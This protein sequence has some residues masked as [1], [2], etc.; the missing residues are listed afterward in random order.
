MN[1]NT[2]ECPVEVKKSHDGIV[3]VK[4]LGQFLTGQSWVEKLRGIVDD[5]IA[6]RSNPRV[7]IDM[8][9]VEHL[10]SSILG[11]LI[12]IY[13][14]LDNASGQLRLAAVQ[15]SVNEI[16]HITRLHQSFNIQSDLDKAAK[17]FD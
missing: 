1:T 4:P 14:K 12:G 11:E 10:S 3:L 9:M 2:S 15:P 7:I 16:F 5:I 17:S 13:R 8:S 6:R